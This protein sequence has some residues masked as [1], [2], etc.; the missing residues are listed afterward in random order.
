[1]KPT[2]PIL[3]A[4]S[5]LALAPTHAAISFTGSHTENFDGLP[6]SGG[7]TTLPGTGI[8]GNQV[9]VTAL[10]DWQVARVG[11][12]SGADSTIHTSALTGGRFYSYGAADAADR[13][14][15]SLGSGSFWGAY[16]TSLVNATSGTITSIVI[17][18]TQEIWTVQGTS[19]AN[20]VEDRVTFAYGFSGADITAA[21]FLTSSAMTLLPA[22][23]LVS[24]AE[25]SLTGV[26]SGTDPD[27]NRDGNST[28]WSELKSATIHGIE[29]APGQEFHIRWSDTDSAGFDAGLAIDNLTIS[30]PEPS[31]V[32]LMAASLI[33]ICSLRRRL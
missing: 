13:A 7:S 33:G 23:D 18:F 2:L 22:L 32:L 9:A 3:A 19:T 24:P 16:G 12:S 26:T 8:V 1:M 27:R 28:Q 20:P 5:V 4:C 6:T 14:L 10:G 21:N 30:I 17:T 29:W 11:G 15:G 31:S 25:S